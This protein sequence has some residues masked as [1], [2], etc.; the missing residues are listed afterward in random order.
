MN[1]YPGACYRKYPTYNDAIWEF[2]NN[3]L[4]DHVDEQMMFGDNKLLKK[5]GPDWQLL[6][7]K[8]VVFLIQFLVIV[9][10]IG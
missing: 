10:A 2:S 8:D 6:T 5:H 7:W 3:H 1:G 9:A 4:I